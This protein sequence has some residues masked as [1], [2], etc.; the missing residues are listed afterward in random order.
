MFFSD[1]FKNDR[2][3]IIKRAINIPEKYSLPLRRNVMWYDSHCVQN[4]LKN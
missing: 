4:N 2:D 1:I 3:R